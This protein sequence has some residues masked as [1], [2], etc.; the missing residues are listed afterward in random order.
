METPR[1]SSALWK[2]SPK[3]TRNLQ[4]W[5]W[6]SCFFP[7]FLLFL[8]NVQALLKSVNKSQSSLNKGGNIVW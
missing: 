6:F 8:E 7:I 5:L 1:M 3:K 4:A 2:R